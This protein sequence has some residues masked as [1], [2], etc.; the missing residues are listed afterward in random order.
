MSDS[1]LDVLAR[2]F[3][4]SGDA[5]KAAIRAAIAPRI[6]DLWDMGQRTRL[7]VILGTVG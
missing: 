2:I 1:D 3:N 5:D 6:R 4:S 7:R